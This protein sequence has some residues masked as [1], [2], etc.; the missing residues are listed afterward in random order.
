MPDTSGEIIRRLVESGQNYERIGQALG[1]NRSLVRQVAIGSKPG[2]NLRESL[3][4]LERRLAGQAVEVTPP[5]PRTTSRGTLARVRKPTTV[6]GRSWASSTVKRQGMRSGGRSLGHALADAAE[7]GRQLA[8]TVTLGSGLIAEHYGSSRRGH[9]GPGGS[10][11]INLGDADDVWAAV[12]DEY[13]GNVSAYIAD[14]LVD[15]GL[16]STADTRVSQADLVEHAA[17]NI[18]EVEL[19]AY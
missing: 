16:V 2:A 4:Q 5:K 11:D 8:A 1:R 13:G 6:R 19:R 7:D 3:E 12:R 17:G 15:R 10:V 9:A 18:A 14:V